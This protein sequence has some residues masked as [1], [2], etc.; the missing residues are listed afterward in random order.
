MSAEAVATRCARLPLA[1]RIV[2]EQAAER[3]DV[4]LRTLLAELS[5]ERDWLDS[6]DSGEAS[7]SVRAVFSWSYKHLTVELARIFRLCG[8]QPCPNLDIPAAS[9]LAGKTTVETRRTL[10]ALSRAHMIEEVARQRYGQHDLLKSY[11]AELSAVND[12]PQE[13]SAALRRLYDYYLASLAVAMRAIAPHE[14]DRLPGRFVAGSDLGAGQPEQNPAAHVFSHQAAFDWL[15]Q[16]RVNIVACIRQADGSGNHLDREFVIEAARA[17]FRFLEAR[18]YDDDSIAVHSMA[19][20]AATQIGDPV[21]VARAFADLGVSYE[22]VDRLYDAIA[23]L[24]EAATIAAAAKDWNTTARALNGRGAALNNLGR[25]EDALQH[26]E[27][28]LHLA[29]L[30]GS[31]AREGH[32][33]ANIGR[34]LQLMGRTDEAVDNYRKAL[35]AFIALGNFTAQGRTLNNFGSAYRALGQERDAQS[36]YERAV[37]I[38]HSSGNRRVEVTA[39]NGLGDIATATNQAAEAL[40]YHRLALAIAAEFGDRRLAPA[41]LGL[42][43]AY[44]ALGDIENGDRHAR[45]AEQYRGQPGASSRL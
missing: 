24:D 38:A 45:L 29:R 30:D 36:C 31:P 21:T 26:H 34:T 33:R 19:L 6:L 43:N 15:E 39:L 28:A 41:H 40:E 23:A 14:S 37:Q 4:T 22:R 9:A 11:A 17:L 8:L 2:A 25:H 3:P 7:A 27:R 32:A 13:R 10:N 1:L 5:D 18:A 20:R 44:H 42:A 12:S 35:D 16:E